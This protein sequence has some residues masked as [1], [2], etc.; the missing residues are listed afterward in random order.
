MASVWCLYCWLWT[1]FTPWPSVSTVN[2]GQVN[3]GWVMT[4][5]NKD[6]LKFCTVKWMKDSN[7]HLRNCLTIRIQGK[8][9]RNQKQ[10]CSNVLLKILIF[11][12]EVISRELLTTKFTNTL[13][14]KHS[15]FW[16]SLS[17]SMIFLIPA[18]Y[19]AYNML[20]IVNQNGQL[21]FTI[22]NIQKQAFSD[23]L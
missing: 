3:A 19:Y 6:I 17:M 21:P 5:V 4:K 1:C 14:F 23:V 15:V 8:V 22:V 13:F 11:T 2:F 10:K 20:R 16:V 9:L 7:G 18:L 12:K